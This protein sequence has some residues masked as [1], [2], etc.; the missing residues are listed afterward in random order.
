MPAVGLITGAAQRIGR[1][2]AATLHAQGYNVVI[3]YHRSAAAAEA[4]TAELNAIREN[5]AVCLQADLLNANAIPALAEQALRP[6]GQLNLLVNNASTYYPSTL[7]NLQPQHWDDLLGSNLKAP[8]LLSDA[9]APALAL[10]QGCIINITD[11]NV[12]RQPIKNHAIYSAAKAGLHG[13]TLALA[14]DLAP[15]VRVNGIAPGAI[16]WAENEDNTALQANI[17]NSTALGRR[18]APEDIANA[19]YFL[20]QAAYITGYVMKVDGGKNMG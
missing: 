14:Q 6:W 11:S 9:C 20:A 13:L 2:I 19:V 1:C 12:L 4:L 3:H 17:I 10:Q 8:A 18:G 7:G 15:K 5:S 16:L